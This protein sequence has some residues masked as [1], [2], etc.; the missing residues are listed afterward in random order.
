MDFHYFNCSLKHLVLPFSGLSLG[1]FRHCT[2][3]HSETAAD[4]RTKQLLTLHT[5]HTGPG[6]KVVSNR[7]LSQD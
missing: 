7:I 4:C 6:D 3:S 1:Y 2:S 5:E